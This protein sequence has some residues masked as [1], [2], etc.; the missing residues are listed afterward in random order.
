MIV[1]P[2]MEEISLRVFKLIEGIPKS[3]EVLDYDIPI[4]YSYLY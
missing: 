2:D 3:V 4:D 1:Q